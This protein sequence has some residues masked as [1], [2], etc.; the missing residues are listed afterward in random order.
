MQPTSSF[1]II[2]MEVA[3]SPKNVVTSLQA[4]LVT[5]GLNSDINRCENAETYYILFAS[6]Y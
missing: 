4:Y 6:V 1:L 2:N 5:E 3:Y